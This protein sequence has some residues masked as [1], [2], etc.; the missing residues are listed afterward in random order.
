MSLVTL[1]MKP[2]FFFLGT[3]IAVFSSP[4]FADNPPYENCSSLYSYKAGSTFQNNLNLLLNHLSSNASTSSYYQA[5]VGDEPDR[6]YGNFMCY[7]YF[8]TQNCLPCVS[9][10]TEAIKAGCPTSKDAVRWEEQCQL[11]YSNQNFFSLVDYSTIITQSN[12]LNSSDP[13]LFRSVVKEMLN[14]LSENAAFDPSQ[15]KYSIGKH[16]LTNTD[17]VYGFVQCT[18]DLTGNDCERC[19]QNATTVIQNCCY[20]YKGARVLTKSCYLRYELYPLGNQGDPTSQSQSKIKYY[21][22]F[23]GMLPDG[24][25]VAVKRLSCS[26]EQGSEEF[27]NEVRLIMKLQHKNLV[28]LLGCCIEG[29]EKILVYEHMHMGSLDGFLSDTEK[30]AQLGWSN[31]FDIVIGIARGLLYLHQDSRFRIIHRDLK[32]SNILLDS[33]LKPK[34]SDFGIAR[35]FGGNLGES[36]TDRIVGT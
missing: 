29:D 12:L 6:V 28:R 8:P 18:Q 20:Y 19:L 31:R 25:D 21:K 33:N 27:M 17:S 3:L 9:Q 10:A 11:R 24:N 34:I 22:P 32:T 23:A 16:N 7:T 14:N 36:N 5:F 35:I 26:S 2:Q 1:A 30:R 13:D 15:Q 4:I